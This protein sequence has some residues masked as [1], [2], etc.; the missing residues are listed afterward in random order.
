MITFKAMNHAK[1]S[2][3]NRPAFAPPAFLCGLIKWMRNPIAL[4]QKSANPTL[5]RI[6]NSSVMFSVEYKKGPKPY[7]LEEG[8]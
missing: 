6:E 8:L 4:R 1:K 2:A 7:V 3:D 5:M